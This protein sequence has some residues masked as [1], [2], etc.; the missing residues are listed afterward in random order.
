MLPSEAKLIDEAICWIE[1]IQGCDADALD[2]VEMVLELQEQFGIEVVDQAIRI[3]NNRPMRK[4]CRPLSGD[5][6]PLWDR[7]LDE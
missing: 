4:P 6:D 2:S 7:E 3:L 5:V 1:Q